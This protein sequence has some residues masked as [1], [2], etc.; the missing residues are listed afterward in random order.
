MNFNGIVEAKTLLRLYVHPESPYTGEYWIT[1][2]I[3]FRVLKL[4]KV[5]TPPVRNII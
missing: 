4:T 5:S 2:P 3:Y 1:E